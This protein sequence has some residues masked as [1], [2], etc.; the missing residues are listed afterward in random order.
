MRAR[1]FVADELISHLW[2]VAVDDAEAPAIPRKINYCRQTLSRVAE[3]VS[4][5]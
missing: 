2:S 4:D 3:L 1:N 5:R